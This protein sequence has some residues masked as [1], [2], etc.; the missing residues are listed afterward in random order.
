MKTT[1]FGVPLW[2][3]NV[4]LAVASQANDAPYTAV[5]RSPHETV[6][7]RLEWTTDSL[8][9]AVARTNEF[10][11][12]ATGLNFFDETTTQQ[13][14]PSREEWLAYADGVVALA[15]RHKVILAPPSLTLGGCVEV[16]VLAPDQV[17][18]VCAPVSLGFYDPVDGKQLV[19]AEVKADCKPE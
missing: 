11:E 19:L 6:W 17:R 1:R 7:Q 4:L 14:Q 2:L 18:V 12:L 10:V 3:A 9:Q 16:D 5:S 15:G 8:G 13:F